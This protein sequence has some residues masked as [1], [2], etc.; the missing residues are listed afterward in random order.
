[1][2][3][4]RRALLRAGTAGLLTVAL[5]G[6]ARAA[7]PAVRKLKL[8]NLHTGEKLAADYCVNGCYDPSALKAI[9]HVLRDHRN[10]E[11]HEIDPRLLDLLH[12]LNGKLET[13]AAYQVISGYRSPQ[14]NAAMHDRSSGVA[15]KS[16][17]MQGMAIDI[18]VPGRALKAVHDNARAMARGGV[19]LYPTS[20]FVHVDVGRV[21]Y[22][23]GV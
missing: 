1:M 3:L 15:K 21:R 6:L 20:N 17:H 4:E 14:S 19:G 8:E 23:S 7:A 11:V 18:R 5:P 10:N 13:P 9:N 12:D 16:L 2:I 22:W